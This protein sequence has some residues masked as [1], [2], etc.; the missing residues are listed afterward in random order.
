MGFIQLG[1]MDCFDKEIHATC[2]L[3]GCKQQSGEVPGDAA[4]RVLQQ[5]LPLHGVTLLRANRETE[6]KPSPRYAIMTK[7]CRTVF[8]A[9]FD[10]EEQEEIEIDMSGNI[11][12]YTRFEDWAQQ[13]HEQSQQET[14]E[15]RKEEERLP[16]M[17]SG[18]KLLPRDLFSFCAEEEVTY[19]AWIPMQEVEVL[20]S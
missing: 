8:E 11:E 10:E 12:M 14:E 17:P 4:A 16:V 5:R 18:Y 7:Y 15:M 13:E 3:P 1:K 6:V 9:T 19:Y 2:V 20:R